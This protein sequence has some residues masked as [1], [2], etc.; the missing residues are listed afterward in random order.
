MRTAPLLSLLLRVAASF[1]LFV[2]NPAAANVSEGVEVANRAAQ[3]LT[4]LSELLQYFG[5]PQT[6]VQDGVEASAAF[7]K[8][9]LGGIIEDKEAL[10][11]AER[12]ITQCVYQYNY[13]TRILMEMNDLADRIKEGRMSEQETKKIRLQLRE[14]AD[15]FK[16]TNYEMLTEGLIALGMLKEEAE[17]LVG[18]DAF[19]TQFANFLEDTA[20]L[21]LKKYL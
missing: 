20:L 5:R 14:L 11:K 9:L 10:D 1:S 19:L 4:S 18:K 7:V 6:T 17:E 16:N 2:I 12:A 21:H 3:G 13:R 15:N 8:G